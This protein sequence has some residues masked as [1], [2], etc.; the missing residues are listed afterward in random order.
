ME[1]IGVEAIRLKGLKLKEEFKKINIIELYFK[2]NKMLP[3]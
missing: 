1:V 3:F 2:Y